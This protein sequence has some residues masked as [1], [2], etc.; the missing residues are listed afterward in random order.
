MYEENRSAVLIRQIHT[1]WEKSANNMLRR[2]GLTLSQITVL[3]ELYKAESHQMELKQLERHL[4]VAQSTTAGIVHRLE[5]K[6]FVDVLP[7]PSD[8]RVKSVRITPE[9]QTCCDNA[10]VSM[11]LEEEHF[12]AALT[13]DEQEQLITLLQKVRDSFR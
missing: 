10:R 13:G 7:S 1:E 9:G 11:R 12:T 5:Q 2:D 6:G 4:H 8:R 3:M